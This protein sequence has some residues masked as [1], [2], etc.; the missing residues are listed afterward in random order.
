[1]SKN[2]QDSLEARYIAMIENNVNVSKSSDL[3][4]FFILVAGIIGFC[5]ILFFSAD[6]LSGVFIN[7]MSDKTQ[8]K[9]E[10]LMS[11]SVIPMD[12]NSMADKKYA[13]QLDFLNKQKLIIKKSNPKLQGKSRF[14]IFVY[15][16]DELNAFVIPNGTIY[17]T[18]GM[19]NTIKNKQALTFVLAHE[20]GHYAN[21][22]HLKGYSR[23]IIAGVVLSILTSGQ[24][25][26]LTSFVQNLGMFNSL[27][28]SRNQ[29]R[30][31]DLFANSVVLK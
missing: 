24:S 14:D 30:N 8:A 4:E 13:E 11:L 7:N 12:L 6:I 5:I 27:S 25:D 3:K 9:I 15:P 28:Y 29:E 22:D 10:N 16:S 26:S 23:Q 18:R 1:M 2:N 17:F 20:M 31:A 19:L 21:R